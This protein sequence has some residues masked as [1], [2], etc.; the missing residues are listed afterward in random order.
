MAASSTG[1]Q[2]RVLALTGSPRKGGNT[3][4]LV[5]AIMRGAE[6]AGAMGE[7]VRLADL[8]IAPC[9]GCGGCDKTG[10]CVIEDDMQGL[11]DKIIAAQVVIIASPIYFYGLSAQT[12]MFVDRLQAIWSRKKLLIAAKEW[13]ARP[14]AGKGYLV[15]VAAT[16]GAKVFM[17][18]QLTA[19]YAFDAMGLAYGGDF[20]V[21]GV[22]LRGD[23]K[24]MTEKL[25][26]A[27]RFGQE[28]AALPGE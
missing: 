18:A 1:G 11:Y 20:L 2:V 8:R 19:Q 25:H 22:E 16:Q 27:E 12:K 6:L 3:E 7:T 10:R 21:R 9:I 28:I 13:P 4:T 5:A 14:A 17:G 24:K 15:A 23:M 26:K